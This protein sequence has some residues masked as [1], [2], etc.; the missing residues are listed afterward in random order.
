VLEKREGR[1]RRSAS[2]PRGRRVTM[3]WVLAIRMGCPSTEYIFGFM[4]C[5]AN[6]LV[7][8]R[9]STLNNGSS[10]PGDE[11]DRHFGLTDEMYSQ[12]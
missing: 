6:S 12:L 10:D 9:I 4:G 2:M 7:A 1:K 8:I 5:G 3:L 11:S